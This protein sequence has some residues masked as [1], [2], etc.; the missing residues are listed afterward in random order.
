MKRLTS[1][2]AE[3]GEATPSSHALAGRR[4][5]HAFLVSSSCTEISR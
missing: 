4:D 1:V 3:A 5:L 2:L